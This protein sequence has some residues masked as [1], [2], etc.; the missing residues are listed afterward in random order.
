[1]IRTLFENNFSQKVL[2]HYAILS[3]NILG[4]TELEE[5]GFYNFVTEKKSLVFFYSLWCGEPCVDIFNIIHDV[6]HLLPTTNLNVGKINIDNYPQISR[7]FKATHVP[8][9]LVFNKGRM[10]E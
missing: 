1:M 3:Q 2:D 9:L 10:K 8:T 6:N 5:E 7:K 4:V